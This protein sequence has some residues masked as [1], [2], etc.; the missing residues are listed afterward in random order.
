MGYVILAS[1][2]AVWVG[3]A[4]YGFKKKWSGVISIGGGF[5][6][7]C[8]ALALGFV[9]YDA[10]TGGEVYFKDSASSAKQSELSKK[11]V[12]ELKKGDSKS[13]RNFTTDYLTVIYSP[14]P[15][16]ESGECQI[17]INYFDG[18]EIVPD[19]HPRTRM[20]YKSG[21]KGVLIA[22]PNIISKSGGPIRVKGNGRDEIVK[23]DDTAMFGGQLGRMQ[24]ASKG[25]SEF[26]DLLE[27]M[28]SSSEI[29]VDSGEFMG[30]R[31]LTTFK[32]N[33]FPDAYS[34]AQ[35]L[36]SH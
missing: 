6:T 19:S 12:A 24:V 2:L 11:I 20:F 5:F 18:K 35:V 28:L 7:A 36:C 13:T 25:S 3:F 1:W 22:I 31:A 8:A 32:M 27:I 9:I 33:D 34:A 30:Q 4:I 26:N 23:V 10:S 15:F 17:T 14:D 16:G 21:E 29:V